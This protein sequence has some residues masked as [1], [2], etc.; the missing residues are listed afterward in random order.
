MRFSFSSD[1]MFSKTMAGNS[2]ADFKLEAVF[3]NSGLS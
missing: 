2:K 3:T 1:I